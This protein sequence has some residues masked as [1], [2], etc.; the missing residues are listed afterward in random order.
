MKQLYISR[1]I[2]QIFWKKT[3]GQFVF[4][5]YNLKRSTNISKILEVD[6]CCC[7][8]PFSDM[9]VLSICFY[10]VANHCYILDT[11]YTSRAI[12]PNCVVRI[13][14]TIFKICLVILRN[15]TINT[16]NQVTIYF[17]TMASKRQKDEKINISEAIT[18]KRVNRICK[19]FKG[20]FK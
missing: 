10:V 14:S 5:G 2:T 15:F 8:D 16:S 3:A 6:T 13:Y 1:K 17:E 12:T 19:T 11:N 9:P 4:R 7:A 18:P 20:K